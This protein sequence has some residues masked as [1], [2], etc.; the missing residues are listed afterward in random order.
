M[1]Q[2]VIINAETLGRGDDSLGAQLMGS[3]LRTLYASEQKP[4]AIVFYNAGV[5]LL[6]AGSPVL[7]AIDMLA[8]AG[9]D[10]VACGTCV[11]FY[12][13]NDLHAGRVSTMKEIVGMMAS[14]RTA[15]TV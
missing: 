14:A 6:A 4:D 10:L 12:K 7:D 15:I 1:E 11:S 3:Y 9:V 5:K 2:L 13:V 8:R